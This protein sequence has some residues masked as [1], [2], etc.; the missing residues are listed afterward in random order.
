MGTPP[1]D[2]AVLS[3][4]VPSLIAP[5]LPRGTH[6]RKRGATRTAENAFLQ[7]KNIHFS[8]YWGLIVDNPR[9][10]LSNLGW[11]RVIPEKWYP[12]PGFVSCYWEIIP[13]FLHHPEEY[14]VDPNLDERQRHPDF[15]KLG[16]G[17]GLP[18]GL[19]LLDDN[20]VACR[21]ENREVTGDS[22]SRRRVP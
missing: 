17:Q 4:L 14:R 8:P 5:R 11:N 2:S 19:G 21:A 1:C 13:L 15:R 3:V 20:H 18:P 9:K 12:R 7:T 16:K 22:C 6:W 10:K